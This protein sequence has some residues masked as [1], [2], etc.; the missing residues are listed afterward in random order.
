[1][2]P[3][4]STVLSPIGKDATELCQVRDMRLFYSKDLAKI[5]HVI[6]SATRLEE[7]AASC[8]GSQRDLESQLVEATAESMVFA[9]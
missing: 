4:A 6:I 8:D 1:M 7:H 5:T 3:K 2:F 9:K